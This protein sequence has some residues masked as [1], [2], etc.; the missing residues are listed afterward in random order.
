M[1][2]FKYLMEYLKYQSKSKKNKMQFVEI[3][4]KMK[5][6]RLASSKEDNFLHC[7]LIFKEKGPCLKGP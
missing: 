2:Y 3:L 4:N 6:R 1:K 5:M 7:S